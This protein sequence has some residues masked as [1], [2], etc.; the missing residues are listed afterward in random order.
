VLLPQS[1][2]FQME[3]LS[4]VASRNL[5]GFTHCRVFEA[6]STISFDSP[7]A[8]LPDAATQPPSFGVSGIDDTLRTLPGGLEIPVILRSH[9][10]GDLAV[11]ALIE[12]VV[13]NDVRTKGS[14]A[15]A[16]GAPVRGRLRRLEHYTSPIPH[17]VIALE[18]TEVEL[19]GIRYRF[20]ANLVRIEPA[21]GVETTLTAPERVEMAVH[22]RGFE[23][24]MQREAVTFNDLPGVATFFFKG[25]R[26]DLGASL[27]TVWKTRAPAPA[28]AR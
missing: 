21:A 2:E 26:L 23:T 16:A 10:A 28:K 20:D 3:M 24:K 13:A 11:G 1:A 27:K 14:V 25:G 8:D 6:Q 19:G 18:Y 4:G 12:G 9:V 22:G 7:A 5:M 17:F 15:I